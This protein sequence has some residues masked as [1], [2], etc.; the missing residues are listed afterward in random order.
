MN[1]NI[2][3]DDNDMNRL[4]SNIAEVSER[5]MDRTQ[6]RKEVEALAKEVYK[7]IPNKKCVEEAQKVIHKVMLGNILADELA[8]LEAFDKETFEH[9]VRVGCIT[10]YAT[11]AARFSARDYKYKATVAALLHD[12]GKLGLIK[13]VLCS[14]KKFAVASE[15]RLHLAKHTEL[16][17]VYLKEKYGHSISKCILNVILNH[18]PR[19]TE[20]LRNSNVMVQMIHFIDVYDARTQKRVYSEAEEKDFVMDTFGDIVTDEVYRSL[21]K[22]IPVYKK[23]DIIY[24]GTEV[25][26][27][28]SYHK[29]SC[30]VLNIIVI[31]SNNIA[32]IGKR[33]CKDMFEFRRPAQFI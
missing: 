2:T 30:D 11:C 22:V 25:L 15:E 6:L 31:D 13:E 10:A 1:R 33:E 26:R 18:H 3:V 28:S 24:C 12:I 29:R 4:R 17:Y 16:G 20:E 5:I 32:R 8:L 9:S 21:I 19:N 23:D 27:V 14:S 7:D